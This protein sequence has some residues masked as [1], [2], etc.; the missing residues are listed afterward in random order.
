MSLIRLDPGDSVAIAR[1]R[2]SAGQEIDGI[3]LLDDIPRGHKVALIDIAKGDPIRKY[4]QSIG[5]ASEPIA[6]GDH[7]HTHN[8]SFVQVDRSY[9]FSTNLRVPHPPAAADTFLGFDRGN[10]RIGTRNYIGII[11][12]VN[13]SASVWGVK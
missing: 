2:L 6:T 5:V 8:L 10:G 11:T 3:L 9:R 12:S 4:A 13:C 1:T 7:V